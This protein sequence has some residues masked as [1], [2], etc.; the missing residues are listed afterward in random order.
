MR[1]RFDPHDPDRLFVVTPR[2]LLETR[3]GGKTWNSIG[4][5]ITDYPW[6]NDVAV[7]PVDPEA[8][9]VAT[10]WGIYRL[11]GRATAVAQ[12]SP[13]VPHEFS[14]D[15]NYPNPFNSGTV[16]DFTLPVEGPSELAIYNLAGQKVR[17]F[18][19]SAMTAGSRTVHWD[20]RDDQGRALASGVYLYRL[21]ADERVATRKLM[22]LK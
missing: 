12:E 20:A 11:D 6:F 19:H 10:S 13:A 17:T 4:R 18:V 3:D 5:E 7:S 22:L 16:I 9:F 14:L 15:Q 2:E 21:E 1:I 8:L